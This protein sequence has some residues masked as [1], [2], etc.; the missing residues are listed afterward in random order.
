MDE[1]ALIEAAKQLY[2]KFARIADPRTLDHRWS[3]LAQRRQLDWVEEAEI[4][5]R[6]YLQLAR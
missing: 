2:G 5:I 6:T 1:D 4:T 3:K